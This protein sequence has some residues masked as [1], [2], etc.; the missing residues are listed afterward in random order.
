MEDKNGK[1][2]EKGMSVEV[3]EPKANDNYNFSFVGC[4][5]EVRE[6]IGD[7]VVIDGDGDCFS[8][9]ADCL[10]IVED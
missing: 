5:E 3:D 2:I 1:R 8:I 7:V 9:D 10:Q 4:V 6:D